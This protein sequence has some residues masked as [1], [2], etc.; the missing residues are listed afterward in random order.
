ME[1]HDSKPNR[2]PNQLEFINEEDAVFIL[3]DVQEKLLPPIVNQEHFLNNLKQL[4]RIL[5][6]FNIPLVVTEQYPRGLGTT[7][8]ELKELLPPNTPIIPKTT[9]SCWADDK[10][11]SQLESL[12]NRKTLII[13]GME[14][15]IC[16]FQT[17]LDSLAQGYKVHVVSDAV[18][19]RA[20]FTS[21]IGLKRMSQAGATITTT[22][23]LV[24]ELLKRSDRPI[25]KKVLPF[26]K[27]F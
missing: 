15:H 18:S 2:V 10:F 27:Q 14:T 20:D 25:F 7:I 26:L 23:M 16:V 5:P 3:I 22:E 12:S 6:E 21:E 1:S 11:K 9:F 13:T 19:S 4:L 17:T 8:P 24:Y